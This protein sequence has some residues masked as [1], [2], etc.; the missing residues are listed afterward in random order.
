MIMHNGKI[1]N[2]VMETIN[3]EEAIMEI[4]RILISH[5]RKPRWI[6]MNEHEYAQIYYD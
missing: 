3:N 5:G 1:Y 6:V 2:E 4:C